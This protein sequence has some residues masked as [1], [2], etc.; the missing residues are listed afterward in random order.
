MQ[1]TKIRAELDQSLFFIIVK[2]FL[3]T[4]LKEYKSKIY[5]YLS[6]S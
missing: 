2:I 5:G 1:Q 6:K 3:K 4:I